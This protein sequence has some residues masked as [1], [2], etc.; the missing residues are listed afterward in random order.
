MIEDSSNGVAGSASTEALRDEWTLVQWWEA[1]ESFASYLGRVEKNRELWHG[2]DARVRLPD[3]LPAAQELLPCAHF[4]VLSEDWCGDAVNT[5][6]VA[7]RVAEHYD[8][9]LRVLERDANLELMDRY[10]TGGRSRSIPVVVA[11][12]CD[13]KELGWWGPRPTELQAWVLGEGM[14]MES[15]DRYK[16][17]RRWYARDKG[18]TTASELLAFLREGGPE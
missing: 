8:I 6:P 12:D 9:G 11:M 3:D 13:F 4:L 17:I 5:L 10:L 15:A 14:E 2:V 1:A 7:A 18:R 16:E